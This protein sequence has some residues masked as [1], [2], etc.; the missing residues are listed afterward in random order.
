[1]TMDKDFT[2][3]LRFPPHRCGGIVVVELYRI[4]V[5]E[6]TAIL[7]T[8]WESLKPEQVARRLV[9]ISRDGIRF[10]ASAQPQS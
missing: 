3:M 5:L 2:R 9:I 4:P 10:R 8:Y 6:A 1:V 7:K